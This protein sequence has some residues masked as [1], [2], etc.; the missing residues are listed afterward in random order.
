MTCRALLRAAWQSR[1]ADAPPLA[2]RLRL[3]AWWQACRPPFFITAAIPVTLALAFAFQV[4]GVLSSR[5]WG[6][7]AL[8][9]LGCFMG[10]TIANFANDLFDHILGVDGGDNIGGSRVIQSG[11]IIPRQLSAALLLL[12]PATLAVGGILICGAPA[13]LRPGL[14]AVSLF[15]VASAVFYVAPPIRYGHRA[16][17][18]VFVCCNMGFII[19]GAGATLLLGRFDPRSLALAL[20]VGLM[21]A[22]VLYYQSLPEI[23]TDAAVGKRTLANSLGKTRAAFLFTLWW[24]AVWALLGNL[25]AVGLAGWPV[26]LALAALPLYAKARAHIAAAGQ[27]DWLPLDKHGALVRLCYLSSGLALIIGVALA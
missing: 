3:R 21:V 1:P 12:T 8:L 19:V 14:W 20:P 16:L 2:P 7:F 4:Q 11:L 6:V 10:L 15:A 25:W 23:D 24:P 5:Q 26:L 18:E 27:G 17:G 9:L 13:A 22:G